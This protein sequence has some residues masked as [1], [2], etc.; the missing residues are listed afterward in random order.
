MDLKI[1]CEVNKESN[2]FDRGLDGSLV[3]GVKLSFGRSC[4]REMDGY[5]GNF[6][7]YLEF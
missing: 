1:I 3:M 6:L 7:D 4:E 2:W 5:K